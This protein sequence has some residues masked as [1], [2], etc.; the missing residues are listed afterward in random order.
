MP[1][2]FVA[3]LKLPYKI[4]IRFYD[5]QKHMEKVLLLKMYVWPRMELY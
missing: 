3:N 4:V 1:L 2:D 5:I